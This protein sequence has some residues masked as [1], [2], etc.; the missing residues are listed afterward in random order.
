MNKTTIGEL[1]EMAGQLLDVAENLGDTDGDFR[2][3]HINAA[4]IVFER[5]CELAHKSIP[6]RVQTVPAV[7]VSPVPAKNLK[8]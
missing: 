8:L 2:T 5:A 7:A 4:K 6:V 1:V 3:G